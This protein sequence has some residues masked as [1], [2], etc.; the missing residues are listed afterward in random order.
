M[1]IEKLLR[2]HAELEKKLDTWEKTSEFSKNYVKDGKWVPDVTICWPSWRIAVAAS[3]APEILS[4]W[5]KNHGSACSSCSEKYGEI[6][7][8][9]KEGNDNRDCNGGKS[10]IPIN[11]ASF[12]YEI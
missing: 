5:W 1:D 4:D 7:D 3:S 9:M 6:H 12:L 2:E 8:T 10:S 11:S